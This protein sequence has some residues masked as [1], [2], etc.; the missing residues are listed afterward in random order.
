MADANMFLVYASSSPSNVPV[1]PRTAPGHI[2]PTYNPDSRITVLPASDIDTTDLTAAI[3]CLTCLEGYG[4]FMDPDSTNTKWVWAFKEVQAGEEKDALRSDDLTVP[5]GFHDAF[6]AVIVDLSRAKT[7]PS[8]S[9][10]LFSEPNFT[11]ARPA[12]VAE[13]H[14]RSGGSNEYNAA[15]AHGILMS[16]FF[17]LLFPLFALSDPFGYQLMK[18]H[19]PLQAITVGV[20]LIGAVLGFNLWDSAGRSTHAHPIL[21]LLLVSTF[22]LV[23]PALGY[24]QHRH[25][26]RVHGKSY[27]AYVHRWIGRLESCLVF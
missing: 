20:M 9:R 4:G 15:I 23:Q 12:G 13:D 22:I 7:D 17:L 14:G 5:I 16:I 10:D 3:E 24:L 27:Y 11:A 25:F 18:I 8:S 21:G 19:A 2:P 6:G 26:V 1:S